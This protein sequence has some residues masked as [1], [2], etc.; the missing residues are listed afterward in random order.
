MMLIQTAER[1]WARRCAEVG[2]YWPRNALDLYWRSARRVSGVEQR[3]LLALRYLDH[4]RAYATFQLSSALASDFHGFLD[5]TDAQKR[6]LV[7]DKL[8]VS[9]LSAASVHRRLRANYTGDAFTVNAAAA[10]AAF[11]GNTSDV[12]STVALGGNVLVDTV[13][14][15]SGSGFGNWSNSSTARPRIVN[16]GTLDVTASGA[17]TMVFDGSNDCLAGPTATAM[18]LSGAPALMHVVNARLLGSVNY[19]FGLGRGT[20]FSAFRVGIG[21]PSMFID[22]NAGTARRTFTVADTTSKHFVYASSMAAGAQVG[23]SDCRQD[24]VTLSQSAV[25]NGT[26]TITLVSTATRWGCTNDSVGNPAGFL[27]HSSNLL[28]L[29]NA[30]LVGNDLAQVELEGVLHQ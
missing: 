20:S 27:N 13:Y 16:S 18:G 29:F 14:D 25:T 28:L 15:Q 4:W 2:G 3:E 11:R 8:S 19:V 12:A 30:V 21:A 23:A 22:I 24:G 6:A 17:P 10:V 9:A 5:N 26:N 7:L 1:A